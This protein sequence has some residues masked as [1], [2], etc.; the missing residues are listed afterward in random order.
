MRLGRGLNGS[1]PQARGAEEHGGL[2]VSGGLVEAGG[3][4][5]E[6]LEMTEEAL[7]VIAL[8]VEGGIDGALLLDLSLGWD[9]GAAA[10]FFD[11]LHHETAVVAAVGHQRLGGRQASKEVLD[12]DFVI[13]LPG[14][15]Q[16]AQG[17]SVLVHHG[18]DL[19]AQSATRTADGVKR[20]PLFPPAACWWARTIELSIR[21]SE[22]GERAAKASNMASHT[23]LRAQRLKR[24]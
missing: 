12:H 9:V 8:A 11:E 3:H 15:E 4:T 17:Q 13:G 1:E 23:P 6:L 2:V 19:G 20:T 21:C 14:R 10:L 7:D 24:L 22:C 16:Q 5:P 18:V